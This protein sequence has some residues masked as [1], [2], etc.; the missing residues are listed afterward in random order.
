VIRSAEVGV[1]GQATPAI[2]SD[3]GAY[4]IEAVLGHGGMGVVYRATDNRLGRNVALKVLPPEYGEDQ[5]FRARF[6]RESRVA[7]S[8][9]HPG[10]IPI[11]E[12]GDADG[13]LYI[14]MRYVDGTDLAELLQSGVRWSRSGRGADRPAR[15]RA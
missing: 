6:L 2:A 15:R 4:R 14:A 1:P 13:Q 9:D 8:I 7:A 3:L 11:Y 10:I 5:T 12:A